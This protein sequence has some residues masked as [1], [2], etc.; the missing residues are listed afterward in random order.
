MMQARNVN[1]A[2]GIDVSH[3]QGHIQWQKVKASGISFAFCKATE[4]TSFNDPLF[5][6]NVQLA[7]K[8]GIS[9]G[10]YHFLRATT[11]AQGVEEAN[12]FIA[13]VQKAGGF[14][15]LD[16]PPVVDTEVAGNTVEAITAWI[17]RVTEVTGKQPIIYTYPSFIDEHLDASLANV[18]LWFASYSESQPKDRGGWKKWMFLQY[19]DKGQVPGITGAVDLDEYDCSA[20]PFSSNTVAIDSLPMSVQDAN[21]IIPY[22][23]AAYK[24]AQT[25]EQKTNLHRLANELRK[26]SGQTIV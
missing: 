24:T 25:Q 26:L 12:H 14:N 15:V 2:Q 20:G 18:P 3:R 21:E 8:A 5:I 4:G 6:E 19:S 13:G 10:G 17:A 16:L 9:V 22:L 7:K 23:S 1:N 11:A